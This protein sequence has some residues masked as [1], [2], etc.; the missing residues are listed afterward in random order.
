MPAI[1]ALER[2]RPE[3]Q[4]FN[5]RGL[6]SSLSGKDNL[7]FLQRTQVHFLTPTCGSQPSTKFQGT[8]CLLLLTLAPG[9]PHVCVK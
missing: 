6:E 5:V 1:P 7:L 3:E 9:M 2:L 8:Q 4:E